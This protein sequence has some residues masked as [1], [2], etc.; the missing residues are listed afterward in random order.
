MHKSILLRIK[1]T[2][3][4]LSKEYGKILQSLPD[5]NGIIFKPKII[6]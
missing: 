5:K 6:N 2:K 3:I 1:W 4:H